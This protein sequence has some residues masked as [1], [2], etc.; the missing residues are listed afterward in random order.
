MVEAR[1]R[2]SAFRGLLAQALWL[3]SH[4]PRQHLV[5]RGDLGILLAAHRRLDVRHVP[6]AEGPLARGAGG[7][8]QGLRGPAPAPLRARAGCLGPE[9]RGASAPRQELGGARRTF[10]HAAAGQAAARG[11]AAVRAGGDPARADPTARRIY[12]GNPPVSPRTHRM[13]ACPKSTPSPYIIG[14][15][16]AITRMSC[17]RQNS[18]A[19]GETLVPFPMDW[20]IHTRRTPAA[21]Q[22][23]TIRS[24]VSGR[25]T[26]TTPSTPPGIDCRSE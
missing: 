14:Q 25:V 20:C 17:R 26:I 10:E 16:P 13:H 19:S 7:N 1:Y 6:P 22:S 15:A 18:T 2:T 4:A 5:Q 12:F 11:N 8:R 9:A 21:P 24:V 3:P 23:R